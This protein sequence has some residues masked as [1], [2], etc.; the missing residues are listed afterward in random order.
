MRPPTDD[1]LDMAQRVTA[2]TSNGIPYARIRFGEDN[3]R[4]SSGPLWGI[5]LLSSSWLASL[6]FAWWQRSWRRCASHDR[7]MSRRG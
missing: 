6:S 3:A 7:K 1:A 4:Q 5:A 2:Y